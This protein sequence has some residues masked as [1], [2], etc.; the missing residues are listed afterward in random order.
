MLDQFILHF[1]THFEEQSKNT[2]GVAISGGVDSV[3]LAFLLKQSGV[4]I[5]LLHCN[6]LLRGIASN[7]DQAF[8]KRLADQWNVPFITTEFNTFAY[9]E[10]Q[11]T[12]I[13]IAARTLRYQWFKKMAKLYHLGSIATAHHADDNLET[14]LINL[15]RGTGLEGLTGIP[16]KNNQ[17]IRPLLPF[18]KNELVAFAKQEN[19]HWR[20]DSS[21]S[22]TKYLRNQLRHLVIPNFKNTNPN[23]LSNVTQTID[24][25]KQSQALIAA[26]VNELK[27]NVFSKD[28]VT[29]EIKIDITI[30]LNE[31]QLDLVLFE[32]LKEYKFTAWIDIK[33]LLNSQ[34]GSKVFS[35]T[36]VLLKNRD[37]L[38]LYE[39]KNDNEILEKYYLNK[40]GDQLNT[41]YG[42][43][44]V[45][46]TVLNQNFEDSIEVDAA[47]I[48][49]P[50]VVR[51]RQEGD[52]FYPSGMQ[53]KKKLNKYF[54]D[55]KLSIFEKDQVWLLCS[56]NEIV[57]VVGKRADRRFA[58]SE[59]TQNKII[60]AFKR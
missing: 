5:A 22:D 14:F 26:Y 48:K 58:V 19:L 45:K 33:N 9:A 43:F 17:F 60:L 10:V 36:H 30:L 37:H 57:W 49:F 51:K 31:A 24:Y 38:L 6:F 8:V 1:N 59:S 23:L 42:S 3:V 34:S 4:D 40:L 50:L 25:L 13:Q 12:S 55:E 28:E 47:K 2:I 7:G 53:G 39:V 15:S 29:G 52:Y 20:E 18:S 56:E 32:L 11:K 35:K 21:N 44:L 27:A 16:E 41:S 46:E 54:K